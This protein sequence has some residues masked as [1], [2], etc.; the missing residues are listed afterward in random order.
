MIVTGHGSASLARRQL[1]WRRTRLRGRCAARARH[2]RSPDAP[3]RRRASL[4]AASPRASLSLTGPNAGI[5]NP[6]H[7]RARAFFARVWQ[8]DACTGRKRKRPAT[9][10][11]A[12]LRAVRLKWVKATGGERAEIVPS[13]DGEEYER[14]AG[15]QSECDEQLVLQSFE[16]VRLP[17]PS[18]VEPNLPNAELS[19]RAAALLASITTSTCHEQ[20]GSPTSIVVTARGALEQVPIPSVDDAAAAARHPR[21]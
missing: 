1:P 5:A 19:I 13:S 16:L 18:T 4:R 7:S 3:R 8:A 6:P 2:M 10:P 14:Q 9:T 12:H 20:H 17:A 15:Q 11:A 21:A